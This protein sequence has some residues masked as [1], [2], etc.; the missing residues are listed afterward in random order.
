MQVQRQRMV[1]FLVWQC[2]TA[3]CLVSLYAQAA[4]VDYSKFESFAKQQSEKFREL[5][6]VYESVLPL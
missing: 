5:A 3:T 2:L 4:D 6:R 1:V